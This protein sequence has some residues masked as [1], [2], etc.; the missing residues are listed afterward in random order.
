MYLA[1]TLQLLETCARILISTRSSELISIVGTKSISDFGEHEENRG[2]YFVLLV[3]TE[4]DPLVLCSPWSFHGSP[5]QNPWLREEWTP[6]LG[7]SASG[8]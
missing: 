1:L 5:N 6:H 8:L 4:L 7:S 2:G 3:A